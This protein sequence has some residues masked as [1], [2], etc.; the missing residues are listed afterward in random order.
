MTVQ[1]RRSNVWWNDY[2]GFF[3]LRWILTTLLVIAAALVL[4]RLGIWQ[5]DRLAQRRA[6]NARVMAG[7][8]MPILNLNQDSQ[9]D[10]LTGMEFRKVSVSGRFVPDEAVLLRNQIWNTQAG[11]HL[12]VPLNIEGRAAAVLVDFG[13]I[14]LEQSD[15]ATRS[16]Y[17]PT[18]LVSLNG[19]FQASQMEP[20]MAGRPDPALAE[21]QNRLDAWNFIALDRIRLQVSDP[22]L[23]VYLLAAPE[24]GTQVLPYRSLPTLDLSEGPHQGYALQWF[25]FALILLL[26]YPFY[27]RKQLRSSTTGR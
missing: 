13:W 23:P 12:L 21:G 5:L 7:S 22:L 14:P 6:L 18:G 1:S 17:I 25:S 27:V 3:S 4:V 15:P 11:S 2:R 16:G 26:G 9:T 24:N 19:I 8:A 20:K 10:A